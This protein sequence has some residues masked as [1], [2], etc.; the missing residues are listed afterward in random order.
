MQTV[1]VQD[2]EAVET[3]AGAIPRVATRWDWRDTFGAWRVRWGIGRMR[4]TVAP[5]LYAVG[6]PGPDAPV[7]ASANYK[8]S[9]DHLRRALAGMDGWVLVLDTRGVNVWC[10]A[11]K[12]TFGTAELVRRI[13]AVQLDRVVS[14]RRIILPQLSAPGV[15]ARL[16]AQESGFTVVF[17]PVY[18]RDIPRFLT[19]GNR[20]P[21]ACRRV[22][23]TWRERLAVAPLELVIHARGLLAVGLA[24]S[25]LACLGPH[26]FDG[27]R[28]RAQ[29]LP[30]LVLWL[31]TYVLA[32]FLGP[33][34][35]PWLPT[36]SFAIK[37]AWLGMLL[38]LS[39]AL[40]W[41]ANW[42]FWRLSAWILTVGAGAS[43]L[44]LNFTGC[45]TFTSPS[46]VRREVRLALPA[47]IACGLGGLALWTWAG[48]RS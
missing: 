22:Q 48:L 44:L 35:L 25:V 24:L 2:G 34:L 12:G 10:A 21:L 46:G 27:A 40:L 5:R 16:A 30:A 39:G 42:S 1:T 29:A 47:I 23:F 11:G 31:A 3:T 19:E 38:A 37:G 41:G 43:F 17:G 18:A 26:G 45:T 32:G 7:F 20:L 28:V 14:H 9:F 36:R 13:Q 15:D 8:L 6:R 33:L 4:Y